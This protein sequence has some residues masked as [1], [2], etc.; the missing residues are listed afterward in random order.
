M[1]TQTAYP[2]LTK[3]LQRMNRI[4][5]LVSGGC[6]S[7]V[8]LRAAADVL[9]SANTVAFTAV[10][11]FIE[12]YYTEIVKATAKELNVKLIQVKLDPLEITHIKA[13]TAMRC[14][15]CKKAI[16]STIKA[17]ALRENITILADGTNLDDTG[18][19]RPGLKAARE[20]HI[21]HPFTSAAMNK[22]DIRNLGRLLNMNNPERPSD[23]CLATRI[24]EQTPIT[25]ST[26]A[27][28]SAIEKPLRP[29]VKG[30]LRARAKDMQITL[31]YQST[32]KELV[33]AQTGALQAIASESGY[34]L[35]FHEIPCF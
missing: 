17:A 34:S 23:S 16:Y 12:K 22:A 28:I 2:A 1:Q 7:E 20:L 13:N 10:T 19:H 25:E 26:L 31:D 30:R 24:P 5:V 9:G 18:E 32:D 21:H 11:P 15:H 35:C 33:K 4:G 6:D 14:Y 29:Y 8:L 27:L 3:E